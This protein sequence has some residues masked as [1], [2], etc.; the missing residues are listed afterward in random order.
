L[1][2]IADIDYFLENALVFCTRSNR[3]T[4]MI[5]RLKLA[6]QI[7][8]FCSVGLP[9]IAAEANSI[10]TFGGDLYAAGQQ[11][12]VATPV[13]GDAFMV[14][15]DVKLGTTV[16]GNAHLAGFNVNA[17]GAI[18]GDLYA[19][20]FSV[21]VTAPVTGNVTAAGNTVS[22]EPAA[23][24][25][26]NA[27]LAG[28]NVLL[29]SPVQGSALISAKD[30]TLQAPITGDLN[31]YGETIA[32]APGA[33]VDGRVTVHAPNE[34]AVPANVASADRVTF[35]R[36]EAP[37]YASQAGQTAE[38]VVRGFWPAVWAF[39]LWWLLLLLI[40]VALISL[41]PRWFDTQEALTRGHALATFGYG[42]LALAALFGLVPLVAITLIG[43]LL[44]P[45][46]FL[47]IAVLL[48]LA[49][50]GGAYLIGLRIAA[51]FTSVSDNRRRVIILAISLIIAALIGFVPFVGWLITLAIV[52]FGLGAITRLVFQRRRST[53]VPGATMPSA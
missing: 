48:S 13:G 50:L 32:F 18:N 8:L 39:A 22:L 43:I 5:S 38:T 7:M 26:R 23:S 10:L 47:L 14:G 51:G 11:N 4:P 33:R 41:Q 53:Q 12:R 24:V 25:G 37:D 52:I 29:A 3:N 20:G 45:A 34:I 31:F 9:C 28:A 1:A 49:Y 46:V 40:G 44:L 30:L 6:L 21:S 19:G 42:I 16:A 35:E 17:D 15:S 2:H 36:M 27:R